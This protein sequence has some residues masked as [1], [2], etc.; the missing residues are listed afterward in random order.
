MS[1]R[2]MH[3]IRLKGESTS[4][5]YTLFTN[6]QS[7]C[8]VALFMIYNLYMHVIKT[9]RQFSLLLH[10]FYQS[11]SINRFVVV[12]IIARSYLR[13]YIISFSSS[14]VLMSNDRLGLNEKPYYFF[15]IFGMDFISSGSVF[16]IVSLITWPNNST[17][18][19]L[20]EA[21]ICCYGVLHYVPFLIKSVEFN[22]DFQHVFL[23]AQKHHPQLEL[24]FWVHPKAEPDVS[25]ILTGPK[26]LLGK[27]Y[28]IGIAL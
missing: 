21:C 1:Y 27:L 20:G 5:S 4:F 16:S 7:V 17:S 8:T 22:N 12:R 3:W 28:D 19:I 18:A 14:A 6:L 23:F 13:F 15:Y 10:N 25:G 24:F 2:R 9:S 11:Y 26:L